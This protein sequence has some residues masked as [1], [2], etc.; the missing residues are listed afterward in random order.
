MKN[1][2]K[3]DHYILFILMGLLMIFTSGCKS[4]KNEKAVVS[5]IFSV[6]SN[7]VIDADGNTYHTVTIGSQDWLVENLRATRYQNGEAIPMVTG[8]SEWNNLATG[9][10]CNY[11]NDAAYGSAYGHLYNWYAVIDSRN[12]CPKGWRVPTDEDW[13]I[14]TSFLGGDVI[15]AGKLK[16]STASYWD[17]PNV[18]ATN[19]SGFTALPAGYRSVKG[20]FHSLGSYTFFWSSTGYAAETAWCRFFQNASDQIDRTD[21]YKAFGFSVRCIKDK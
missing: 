17:S 1:P 13:D 6:T 10:F 14:L 5:T 16:E 3:P 8:G 21:N 7:E 15:A 2:F 12:I 4:C 20:E 18:G 11:E 9:A 19:E